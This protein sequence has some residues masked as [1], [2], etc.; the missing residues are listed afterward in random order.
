MNFNLQKLQPNEVE[1]QSHKASLGLR[2]S[3]QKEKAW[4]KLWRKEKKREKNGKRETQ[5]QRQKNK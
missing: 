4:L 1:F 3:N 2:K 5:R